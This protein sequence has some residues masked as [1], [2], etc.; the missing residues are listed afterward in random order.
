MIAFTAA[1]SSSGTCTELSNPSVCGLG[2]VEAL[3]EEHHLEERRRGT[4]RAS[5][6]MIIIGKSPTLISGVPS[7]ASV[8]ATANVEAATSPSPPPIA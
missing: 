2:R 3:A 6:A 7:C 4:K 1:S 8:D 5:T